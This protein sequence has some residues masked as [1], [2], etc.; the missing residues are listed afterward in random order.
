VATGAGRWLAF[1]P[2]RIRPWLLPQA[3]A[4]RLLSDLAAAPGYARTVAAGMVDIPRLGGIS[5]PVLLVQGTHDPL[6]AL[7]A[8]RFLAALPNAQLR[9]LPALSHVPISDDPTAVT[10]LM[11]DFLADGAADSVGPNRSSKSQ[12]HRVILGEARQRAWFESGA[13]VVVSARKAGDVHVKCSSRG[14]G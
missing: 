14:S 10:G 6:V 13:E 9:W 4:R 11:I 12:T 7:Q 1:T 8:L 3:D 2:D 5:C